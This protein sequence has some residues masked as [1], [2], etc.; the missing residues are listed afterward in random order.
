L[1][2]LFFDCRPSVIKRLSLHEE[3][4]KKELSNGNSF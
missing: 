4:L 3:K 1:D 2:D